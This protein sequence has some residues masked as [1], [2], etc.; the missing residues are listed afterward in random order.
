[1]IIYPCELDN[2]DFRVQPYFAKRYLSSYFCLHRYIIIMVTVYQVK[3][4]ALTFL[5]HPAPDPKVLQKVAEVDGD[6]N[7]AFR[8]TQ[9][10]DYSWA[11][12]P[13]EKVRFIE[14]LGFDPNDGGIRSTSVG[15][16]M[17]KDGEFYIVA[18]VG[19]SKI[20]DYSI[21]VTE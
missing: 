2:E 4:W 3:S 12:T 16:V 17:E 8:L 5:S 7:D 18:F 21:E 20:P 6:L 11:M 19:F 9:N 14:P 10:V 13:H 15:D 1:M